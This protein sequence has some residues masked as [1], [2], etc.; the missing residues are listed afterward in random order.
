MKR[1]AF[2]TF[3]FALIP[4][5]GQMFQGYMKRGLSLILMFVLPIMVGALVMPTLMALAAVVYM[6]SFFDAMNLH[7]QLKDSGMTTYSDI[8]ND[9]YLVHMNGLFSGDLHKLAGGKHHLIGWGLIA[10]GILALYQTT[11]LPMLESLLQLLPENVYWS[12]RNVVR[13]IP[14]A[15]VAVLLVI[16]GI[17]LVR[18]SKKNADQEYP[19][20]KGEEK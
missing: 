20:Y 16:V 5:A 1:N 3:L 14:S 7:S 8:K 18:G 17:W 9:D 12:L 4:G 13:G 11:L 2:L 15:A 10:L 6:Y 19:Y